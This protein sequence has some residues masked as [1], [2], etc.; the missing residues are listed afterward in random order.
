MRKYIPAVGAKVKLRLYEHYQN[1]NEGQ[2]LQGLLLVGRGKREIEAS[3]ESGLMTKEE[4][5]RM[6]K[7]LI[8][9]KALA[10]A[11]ELW[12]W[13]EVVDVGDSSIDVRNSSIRIKHTS[14]SL[15]AIGVPWEGSVPLDWIEAPIGWE[16]SYTITCKDHDQ[17]LRVRHEWFK[18]GI[19]VWA[20]RDLSS[21]GRMAFTPVKETNP[22]GSSPHWQ[23]TGNPVETILPPLCEQLFKIE[24]LTQWEPKL[25][26]TS[27]KKA[28]RKAVEELRAR[29]GLELRFVPDG[30]GG[31]MAVCESVE[32]S[33][34]PAPGLS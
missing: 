16:P 7:K 33:Y 23:F 20:S 6:L 24:V 15:N 12:A 18:V 4:G 11:P 32:T 10:D 27:E 31:K 34:E 25:P 19:H 1:L 28:R 21:A 17:A 13:F 5:D 14:R 9:D 3:I 22:S 29:P 2:C 8:E 30:C 26:P